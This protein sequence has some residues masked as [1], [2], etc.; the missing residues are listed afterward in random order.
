MAT[1][2]NNILN[3]ARLWIGK[4]E[5]NGSYKEIIDIYNNHKPLARNYKVKYVD[6]WCATFISALA[7]VCNATDIIPLEC[8]CGNMINLAKNM[9]VWNENGSITPQ[10]G[11]IVMY[12]W[13][14]KDGWPDHVGIVESISGNQ[15]TVIEGNKN[16]A[17]GRRTVSVGSTSIR[18][19]IT[20]KYNGTSTVQ[21]SQPASGS[22]VN[23][24][25][26]VNTTS[27]V[28]CRAEPSTKGAKITAYANGVELAITKESGNWG[29]ANN[30]GWV[31]LDYCKKITAP[32]SAP[33][34]STSINPGKTTGTYEVTASSL[35]V[36]TGPETTYRRKSKAELTT[37]G[38]KHA[39]S[40]GG[41]LKGTRVT[42]S[43]WSGNWAYIPSG[44]VSGDYLKKV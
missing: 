8:S 42:V 41:L 28:N 10:P 26:K 37:D 4:K 21:P 25:V 40:N 14:K 17:V 20:P 19:F 32:T 13:D 15:F 16:D 34:P 5:S 33:K 29:Y 23:Y 22:N 39:N 6:S 2:V 7:I 3:Q 24:K 9:G 31:C 30:V 38:Q 12:D 43:K 1:T 18:G 27:G 11:Y 35:V 36:R 44:W